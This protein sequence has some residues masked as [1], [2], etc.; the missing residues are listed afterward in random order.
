[1]VNKVILIGNLG[2]DPEIKRFENSAVANFSL[3]TSETYTDKNGERQTLTEW[4]NI[5]VWG[6]QAEIAEQYLHKGS[7]VY[8]EGKI[9]NRKYQDKEGNDR[10][11]TEI[12]VDQFKMLD[13]KE[14]PATPPTPPPPPESKGDDLPF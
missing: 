6:R 4:H 11:I 12:K 9:T 13:P 7:K 3:A 14:G 8:V 10:F 2:K 1:M 5:V